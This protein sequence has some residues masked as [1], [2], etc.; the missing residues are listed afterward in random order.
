MPRAIIFDLG[1]TVLEEKSYNINHGYKTISGN[2]NSNVSIEELNKAITDFQVGNSEFKLLKWISSRLSKDHALVN[3]EAVELKL[4]KE[5]VSLVP[6][7]GIQLVLDFLV[8]QNVRVAAISN[9]I[10][11]SPCMTY[12]LERHNLINYF[13]FIISSADLG[14]R[15]P[16]SRKFEIAL[17]TLRLEPHDVW[18]IGDNWD[19]DIIG[20][21][22]AQMTPVWFKEQFPDHDANISHIKLRKWSEFGVVW[23]Q[24]T[25][26]V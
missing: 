13:E 24:H 19:A 2:L 7:L 15:K 14:I 8:K 10:F 4:W 3:A 17:E 11:S 1:D 9:A 20:A 16:D 12:E 25:D 5:T 18:Y 22:S 23:D 21:K 6:K 26:T